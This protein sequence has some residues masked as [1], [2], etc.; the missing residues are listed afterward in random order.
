MN[1]V[2]PYFSENSLLSN[3]DPRASPDSLPSV[4][5]I[6]FFLSQ[7]MELTTTNMVPLHQFQLLFFCCTSNYFVRIGKIKGQFLFFIF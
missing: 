5:I 4:A 3:N 1:V 6:V 7:I 2:H